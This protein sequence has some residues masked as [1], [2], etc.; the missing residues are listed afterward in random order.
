MNAAERRKQLQAAS[1]YVRSRIYTLENGYA[2]TLLGQYK[3]AYDELS[4]KLEQV[5]AQYVNGDKWAATDANFRTR[6]EALLKQI[7]DEMERLNNQVHDA[8]VDEQVRTYRASY[9]GNAWITSVTSN[10]AANIPLLPTEAVRA[11]VLFPY[12]NGTQWFRLEQNRLEFINKMRGSMIQSQIQGETVYQ[13][14]K[15]LADALGLPIGR[16]TLDERQANGGN[17]H[18]TEM[19]ARTELLRS[20]NLGSQAVYDANADIVKGWRFEAT[21][22]SRTCPICG[23]LDGKEYKLSDTRNMPPKHP[24]CRCSTTPVLKDAVEMG[25]GTRAAQGGPVSADLTYSEW[26]K[27]NL[28]GADA[29]GGLRDLRPGKPPKSPGAEPVRVKRR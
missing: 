4:R 7:G 12:E 6:T 14:Q 10:G 8:L 16:R 24:N 28:V 22:D 25:G 13:A 5:F 29:D 1:D 23:P 18:R 9:Y 19:I 3:D 26:A 20:S 2:R 17:F 27:A 11:Q 15:R 21:L